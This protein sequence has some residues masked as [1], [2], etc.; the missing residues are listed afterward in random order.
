VHLFFGAR[1]ADGLYDLPGLEKM[2]AE[3]PWLTVVPAVSEGRF[4]GEV[5][6]LADVVARHGA[7]SDREV[8][9]AGPTAMVAD[10]TSKLIAAGLPAAQIHV[11]DF[12]WSE[13]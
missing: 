11:E 10:C 5:G 4:A 2:A 7:W 9:V 6:A 13:P 1:R 8:Y 12:G 3:H